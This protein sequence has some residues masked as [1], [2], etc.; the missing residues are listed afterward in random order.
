[1]SDQITGYADALLA[2]ARADGNV[3]SVKSELVAVSSAIDGNEELRQSLSNNLLPASTRNQILDDILAKKVSDTTR[4][5][6]GMIISA[7]KGSAFGEIV[8]AFVSSSASAGGA[9]V[10]TVRSAVEL[11]EDQKNRLSQ[12]LKTSTG[13]DVELHVVVD[14]SVVGGAVTTI[15]D[16]VIDGSLRTRLNQMRDAL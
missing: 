16:T 8:K 6:A 7:G 12:A 13:N 3:A 15:G 14:P 4:A 1:M 11:T 2:V 10:A 9:Q 5:L